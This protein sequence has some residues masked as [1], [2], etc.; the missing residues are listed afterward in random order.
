MWIFALSFTQT[1]DMAVIAP[2]NACGFS[3][4]AGNLI[5]CF[6]D[7]EFPST[8]LSSYNWRLGRGR[9][10][11]WYG[12]P[13]TDAS[14]SVKGGYAFIDISIMG[15]GKSNKTKKAWMPSFKN[16]P[17][18]GRGKCLRFR[19][20]LEGLCVGGL[21][22]VI[23]DTVDNKSYTIWETLD[24]TDGQWTN[25]K[26]SYTRENPYRII[27]ETFPK[28]NNL[29]RRGFAAIDNIA[30]YD[31]PCPG[32]CTFEYDFCDW[33]NVNS[34]DDF[35]WKMGRGSDSTITGPERDHG[36]SITK[37]RTGGYA[38]IDSSYP[39]RPGDTAQL[40]SPTLNPT[41]DHG[42]MC[43]S[44]FT[45]MFGAGI[46]ALRIYLY[47]SLRKQISDAVWSLNSGSLTA[48]QWHKGEVT[49]SLPAP[50]WVIFEAEVRIPGQGDI[51]LDDVALVDGTCPSV[52][53]EASRK[54]DC[55]FLV[56][57]CGWQ[58][59]Y[60]KLR[61]NSPPLWTRVSGDGSYLNPYGHTY[62]MAGPTRLD[63]YM[64]FDTSNFQHASLDRGMLI[65]PILETSNLPYC[66]SFWV[67]L[68]STTAGEPIG[69]ILVK[70]IHS[71]NTSSVLW[72]LNN[73]QD[74]RWFFAQVNLPK[75]ANSRVAIE[76]IKGAES[77]SVIAIDDIT[78]TTPFKCPGK[79]LRALTA[80]GDCAFDVDLC[81][82][83]SV[84]I[85]SPKWRVPTGQARPATVKDH[86]FN[87]PGAGFV[88]I[89]VFTLPMAATAELHSPQMDGNK[90]RCFTFWYATIDEEEG[91]TLSIQVRSNSTS[92]VVWIF[93]RD[94]EEE[95]SQTTSFS[96]GQ[97]EVFSEEDYIVVIGATVQHSG[98]VI[99]DIRFYDTNTSCPTRPSNFAPTVQPNNL[100]NS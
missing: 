25:G 38:Y 64:K 91:A 49:L 97:V 68:L 40:W 2:T 18:T 33:T 65:S 63:S 88:Y 77:R 73:H 12:G 3:D 6:F 23:Y 58:E 75:E 57:M 17:T 70:L 74:S 19:Y 72:R 42:P 95:S 99:D 61:E 45:S 8:H 79:P 86:T 26:V 94:A 87:V 60:E 32:D 10:A 48:D 84:A 22:V 37:G 24:T 44:F 62:T 100:P 56:D 1:T 39:R 76:A 59:Y 14:G 9:E 13:T 15:K 4:R 46:G 78:F 93:V 36:S 20:N 82:W 71:D 83:K 81:E 50:Y 51:A 30:L 52:P 85:L 69:G 27:F 16:P 92:N 11:Y 90:S 89:D 7:M 43:L 54:G 47:D 31:G 67:F 41:G 66:L 5:S 53:R 80:L 29:N 55:A 96:F 34:G 21:R 98:F 28:D 35:D